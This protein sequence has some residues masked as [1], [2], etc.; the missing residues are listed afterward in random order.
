MEIISTIWHF[1]FKYRK[2]VFFKVNRWVVFQTVVLK[3]Q[4]HPLYMSMCMRMFY[5]L[6]DKFSLLLLL[7]SFYFISLYFS[8][9]HY[10][11]LIAQSTC[12]NW[13]EYLFLFFLYISFVSVVVP[14]FAV[15]VLSSVVVKFYL[16]WYL[17][18]VVIEWFVP[19]TYF[20][21]YWNG[22]RLNLLPLL[23]S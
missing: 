1:N 16:K 14:A 23:H 20:Y 15:H 13:L 19:G 17:W 9:L 18:C 8:W 3:T 4:P 2:I 10:D 5:G 21:V 7:L 12:K 11:E 6:L 22:S